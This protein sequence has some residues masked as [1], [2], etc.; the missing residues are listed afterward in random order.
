MFSTNPGEALP[1]RTPENS[2][3]TTSSVL[4]ILSS[5]SSKMSSTVISLPSYESSDL[6]ALDYPREI[7]VLEHVKN[8]Y[9]HFVV[10]AERKRG[11]IHDL[12]LPLQS[13]HKS[14]LL[15][16]LRLRI[17]FRITVVNT[18]HLCGLENHICT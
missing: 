11:R 15:K 8:N 14:D 18:V 12:E 16:A 6:L 5:A 17:L 4:A 7:I 1:V 2:L 9:R 10:H 3:T 13:L